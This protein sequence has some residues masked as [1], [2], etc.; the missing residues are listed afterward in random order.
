MG[1]ISGIAFLLRIFE[2]DVHVFEDIAAIVCGVDIAAEFIAE[3][4]HD[5]FDFVIGGRFE[6]CICEAV[7]GGVRHIGELKR[8]ALGGFG[9]IGKREE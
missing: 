9:G 2:A 6:A 4:V 7:I 1:E 3:V 8:G 5:G